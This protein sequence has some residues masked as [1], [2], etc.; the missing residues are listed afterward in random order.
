M[1]QP[2]TYLRSR[3][4]LD[5]YLLC[6]T[7]STSNVLAEDFRRNPSFTLNTWQ[8]ALECRGLALGSGAEPEGMAS[9]NER[10]TFTFYVTV[11]TDDGPHRDA[12]QNS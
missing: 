2:T 12:S 8:L 6:D 1:D 4:N 5:F 3:Q 10:P 7:P 9:L 11:P